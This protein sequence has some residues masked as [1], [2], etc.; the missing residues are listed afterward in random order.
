MRGARLI[1][2]A[3]AVI[4]GLIATELSAQSQANFLVN[5]GFESGPT[6]PVRADGNLLVLPNT[7]GALAWQHAGPVPGY[8]TNTGSPLKLN[9]VQVDGPG[10]FDYGIAGNQ[11]DATG[12][13]TRFRRRHYLDMVWDDAV[14]QVFVAPCEG[15]VEFGAYFSGRQNGWDNYGVSRIDLIA[16]TNPMAATSQAT[17]ILN[18]LAGPY[19]AKTGPWQLLRGQTNVS[20]GASYVFKIKLGDPMSVD[21]AF[22]K[23][24]AGCR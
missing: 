21:E 4:A 2:S 18:S 5:G 19:Q 3:S 1:F 13:H 8:W 22:V 6:N 11:S 17:L 15:P 7:G 23:P 20:R 16:G 10:G 14:Y 24:T 9:I 12:I